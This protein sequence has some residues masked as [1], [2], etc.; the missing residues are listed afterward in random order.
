MGTERR[1]CGPGIPLLSC[2]E[3][4]VGYRGQPL[5]PPIDFTIEHGQLCAVVGRN[6][7]GKTTW[8]RTM[9]GLLPPISGAIE[10]CDHQAPMAYIPQRA[11]L[12]PLVPLPTWEV[13]A[14]GLERGRSFLAPWLSRDA[15]R[16]VDH[17]LEAME[18]LDLARIPFR[19][20]SEGQKQRVLMARLIV[21]EPELVVLDEPTAAMDQ[22][23]EQETMARIDELR[24][25]HHLAVMIVSHHLPVVSRF[26]DHVIFLDKDSQQVVTGAPGAVFAHPAFSARYGEEAPRG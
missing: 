5:L 7:A 6:G 26:A 24:R 8:F 23:A 12:D 20:L 9:M 17:A 13:V 4:V 1:R 16:R 21:S 2:R 3:L 10:T 22:V 19:E 14:M 18:A 15:R 25:E 11:T